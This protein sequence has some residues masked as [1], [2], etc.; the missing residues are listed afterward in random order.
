VVKELISEF[1][2][3]G[4]TQKEL[5]S[6]KKFLLGSEP[7]RNEI[8]SQRL[9]KTFMEYYKGLEIGY[10]TKELELIEALTL[11]SLNE[12]IK[13]HKEINNLTFSIV[14]NK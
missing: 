3:N 12:F 1:V 14:T 9:S 2:K 7:L 10:S 13:S 8:L 4:V 5:D 11:D 6:A